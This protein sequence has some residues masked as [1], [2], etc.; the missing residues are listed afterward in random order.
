MAE[1]EKLPPAGY[2]HEVTEKVY[3]RLGALAARVLAAGH[4]AIVDAVFARPE[5]RAAIAQAAG[6]VPFQGLFLTADLATRVKRVGARVADASDA[7]AGVARQQEQY[8]LGQ[9]DWAEVDAG[10]TPQETL[11]KAKRVVKV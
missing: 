9:L 7:D 11:E 6:T 10:G 5:E 2:A 1:T 4:S 3:A 8:Q